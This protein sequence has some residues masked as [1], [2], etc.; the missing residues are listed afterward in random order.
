MLDRRTIVLADGSVRSY[1]ALPPDYELT[2]SA[3]PGPGPIDDKFYPYGF[4]PGPGAGLGGFDKH[5]PPPGRL[6]PDAFRR[7]RDRDELYG[8]GASGSHDYWNSLGLDGRGPPRPDSSL[9]RKYGEDERR[10]SRDEFV[11]QQLLQYGNPNPNGFP[12]GDRDRLGYGASGGSPSQ[13]EMLEL[14]RGGMDDQRPSKHMKSRA[15]GYD[16]LPSRR[17]VP[18][19]DGAGSLDARN[20]DVNPHALNRAFLRFVKSLNESA[21]Q[22][23]NYLED[24]KHGSLRCLVCDRD[25]KDYTDV[26]G[27]IMHAYSSQNARADHLGF[28]KAVCVL[29]GWNHMRG[30]DHSKAY[31]SLPPDDAAANREDLIIWPPVVVIHNTN[32]GRRKDG[33]M[34]GMGNKEM[35][36]K[37]K[38]LG[39]GGGKSKSM[40]GKD[41]HLGIT[42][43]KFANTQ[44]GL[45]EAERFAEYFE[46]E[47]HGRKG[48]TRVQASHSGDVDDNNPYLV[49]VDVKSGEKKRILYG[50]LGTASDLDKVDFDTKKKSDIKSRREFD[51]SG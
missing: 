19:N 8:R 32:T 16:E 34:D 30:P 48:W 49:K 42:I 5:Y 4:E 11:R 27:L 33:R 15:D 37:L 13:R 36:N 40:Y 10:D 39:F 43:V 31:Q 29:M 6:S 50:Y 21:S 1:F 7:E 20:S 2:A 14:G 17:G 24:G 35:D 51:Q 3:R 18:D 25:S 22:R 45:K 9:K 12:S 38:D 26:H 47:N 41:G 23:K 28:H 46:K 44:S